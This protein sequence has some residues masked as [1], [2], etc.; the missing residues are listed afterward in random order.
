MLERRAVNIELPDAK[1][2]TY[3]IDKYQATEKKLLE[4]KKEL[5][6]DHCDIWRLEIHQN[7]MS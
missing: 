7:Q 2:H 3:V 6:K 4:L 1:H 5:L